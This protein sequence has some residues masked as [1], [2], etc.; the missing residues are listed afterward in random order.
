MV[1]HLS[2]LAWEVPL[3]EEP[4][5]LQSMW[6]QRVGHDLASKKPEGYISSD[7]FTELAE[8]GTSRSDKSSG[9]QKHRNPEHRPLLGER[10]E[11]KSE[12]ILNIQHE[13]TGCCHW[14][15]QRRGRSGEDES[16]SAVRA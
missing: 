4:G 1:T 16:Q 10:E 11:K 6:L 8:K 13:V 12:F 3:T 9:E 14:E 2:I 7:W 5:R 15:T